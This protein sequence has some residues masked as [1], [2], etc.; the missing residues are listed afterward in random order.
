[1]GATYLPKNLFLVHMVKIRPRR[2]CANTGIICVA[3]RF[4]VN[5]CVVGDI[6][7]M[8]RRHG[9]LFGRRVQVR[10][11]HARDSPWLTDGAMELYGIA[12]EG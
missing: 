6:F 2:E 10:H 1:M 9:D 5:V 4:F 11:V 7:I 12:C 3:G 8:V